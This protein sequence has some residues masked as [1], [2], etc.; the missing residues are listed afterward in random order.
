V[1]KYFLLKVIKTLKKSFK[2]NNS[3]FDNFIPD[4][5]NDYNGE[6]KTL[7]Q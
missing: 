1:A 2:H 3:Y 4:N 5:L 7:D 6:A